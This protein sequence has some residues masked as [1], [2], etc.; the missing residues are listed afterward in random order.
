MRKSS[1]K[2]NI[3][4][5]KI[6]FIFRTLF[7]WSALILMFESHSH[8]RERVDAIFI[9][10]KKTFLWSI[11]FANCNIRIWELPIH[12]LTQTHAPIGKAHRMRHTLDCLC[13]HQISYQWIAGYMVFR[14]NH[15][16]VCCLRLTSSK[17]PSSI[18]LKARARRLRRQLV[19]TFR[20]HPHHTHENS[21]RWTNDVRLNFIFLLHVDFIFRLV[22][23]FAVCF[24]FH[25]I[26]HWRT[27]GTEH[28]S[29]HSKEFIID[30]RIKLWPGRTAHHIIRYINLFSS[31]NA[32]NIRTRF[33]HGDHFILLLIYCNYDGK[34]LGKQCFKTLSIKY[35]WSKS[36]WA[37]TDFM[38]RPSEQQFNVW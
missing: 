12:F 38:P 27:N 4:F 25:R 32:K 10:K 11:K 13:L 3:F 15:E 20:L 19:Y 23:M 5:L 9:W 6:S 2:I 28:C 35:C 30:E 37:G 26:R 31:N 1:S 8:T 14:F 7:T 17:P 21:S 16:I 22:G 33:L 34:S 18:E 36:D 29:S 24:A